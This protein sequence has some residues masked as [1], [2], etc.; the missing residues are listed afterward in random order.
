MSQH[1]WIDL[2]NANGCWL[3]VSC[4]KKGI[5][6]AAVKPKTIHC[7][8]CAT[9]FLA[10]SARQYICS[11]ECALAWNSSINHQTGCWEKHGPY[12]GQRGYCAVQH[13]GDNEYGHRF[14]YRLLIGPIPDGMI[15]RHKCDNPPCFNPDHLELGT[16]EQNMEDMRL[17]GRSQTGS[18][19]TGAKLTEDQVLEIVAS[20]DDYKTLGKRFS[21]HPANIRAIKSGKS[22]SHLT[23]IGRTVQ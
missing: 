11:S 4:W 17:R 6:M 13:K 1:A 12:R 22:W 7:S 9:P 20:S 21:V 23:G 15:V 8:L 10:T 3:T 14:S 16:H 19:N 5:P 18:R 2:N